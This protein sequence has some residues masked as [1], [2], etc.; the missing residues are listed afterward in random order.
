MKVKNIWI[1]SYDEFK[2]I[3]SNFIKRYERITYTHR[4]EVPYQ[5]S[6]KSRSIL[7]IVNTYCSNLNTCTQCGNVGGKHK[8]TQRYLPYVNIMTSKEYWKEDNDLK[9]CYDFLCISCWNKHRAI[10]NNIKKVFENKT[11][12]NK[13]NKEIAIERKNR[14][15][16]T[17]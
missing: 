11:L 8:V 14:D 2:K 1:D 5:N 17:T 6:K 3:S 10:F 13:I 9:M 16:R 4:I 7:Y 15:N 12:I